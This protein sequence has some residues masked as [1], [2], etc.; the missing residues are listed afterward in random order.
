MNR[1]PE[2]DEGFG[3]NSAK[4]RLLIKLEETAAAAGW[5]PAQRWVNWLT[6]AITEMIKKFP[7]QLFAHADVLTGSTANENP[8]EPHSPGTFRT[9]W[10]AGGK[11]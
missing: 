4:R 10:R 3:T 7:V 2:N 8:D 9:G 11:P 1:A 6:L 5:R